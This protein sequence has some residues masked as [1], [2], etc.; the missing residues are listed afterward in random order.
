MNQFQKIAVEEKPT[1]LRARNK[2][3]RHSRILETAAV[4]FRNRGY[5]A[6]KI[7][8][9]ADAAEVSVGTIYNYY[10]NKGDILVALVS[11]EVNE[12]LT[13]GEKVVQSP[14]KDA[15]AAVER[16]ILTYI[17]HSLTYLSKEMWRQAM[18]ISTIQ[19]TSPA[20]GT[21]TDLDIA[22]K[23]QTGRL[24]ARLIEMK[25]VRKT[26]DA[27]V[28]GEMIF[29]GQNDMFINFVKDDS[30]SLAQLKARLRR[31]LRAVVELIAIH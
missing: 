27:K 16:L 8:E 23:E 6:V 20:G 28:L 11:L 2:E 9:I 26:I 24:L 31:N 15:V 14:P 29:H 7:E 22:L 4:M 12:V 21:Y 10:K 5:E 18:A 3:Q 13:L 30:Q 19:P 1:G 17:D 25:S